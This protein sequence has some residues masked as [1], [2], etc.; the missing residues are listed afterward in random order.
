MKSDVFP[1]SSLADR[2]DRCVRHSGAFGYVYHTFALLIALADATDL[3]LRQVRSRACTFPGTVTPSRNSI[4]YIFYLCSKYEMVGIA[5]R[6]IIAWGADHHVRGDFAFVKLIRKTVGGVIA[7]LV[8]E[9]AVAELV[10]LTVPKPATLSF[11]KA[12]AE[13][14]FKIIL[15]FVATFVAAI[16]PSSPLDLGRKDF[17][18]RS[19][20]WTF[21]WYF[22]ASHFGFT[23][24]VK[25]NWLGLTRCYNTMSG[26]FYFNPL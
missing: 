24:F 19:A 11:R 6:R 22:S 25:S 18:P 12:I 7:V 23:S 10:R 9:H 4:A 20:R 21:S 1:I 2:F 26:C 15:R 14:C 5:A 8:I 3:L 17:E 13:R 16:N